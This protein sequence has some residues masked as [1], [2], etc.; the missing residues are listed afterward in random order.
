VI[1]WI[2]LLYLA[3]ALMPE[4]LRDNQSVKNVWYWAL[5][6][7]PVLVGVLLSRDR[8]ARPLAIGGILGATVMAVFIWVGAKGSS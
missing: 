4:S 2:P 6:A 3:F 5:L 7:F 1:G 8:D